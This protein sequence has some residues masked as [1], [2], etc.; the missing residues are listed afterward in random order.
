MSLAADFVVRRGEHT[1]TIDLD[2][3]DGEVIGLIGP[4][5]AGKSTTLRALAGLLPIMSGSIALSGRPLSSPQVH[6]RRTC[7][8]WASC[9]RTT[10][11][12]PT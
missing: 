5:G 2:V 10:C 12:S 7:A 9:S 11:C 1:T 6:V 3:A 8:G 4:N